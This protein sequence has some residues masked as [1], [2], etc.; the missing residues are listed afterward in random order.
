MNR[1]WW[2]S[3][4]HTR[5]ERGNIV[6]T[7]VDRMKKGVLSSGEGV[8]NGVDRMERGYSRQRSIDRV[9]GSITEYKEYGHEGR[10]EVDRMERGTI[11]AREIDKKDL[12]CI[13]KN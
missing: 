2:S 6:F 5:I 12:E 8:T 13:H 9:E 1:E 11:S 3:R 7:V 10:R 4:E